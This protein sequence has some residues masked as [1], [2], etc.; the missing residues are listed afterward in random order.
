MAYC[1]DFEKTYVD[2]DWSRLCDHFTD[3]GVYDV[4]AEGFGCHLEGPDAIFTG[5][6]KS[7]DGFDR[8]FAERIIQLH[9]EPAVNGDEIS[10]SWQVT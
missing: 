4:K 2:E 6:K 7:L 3:D 1:A 8:K 9:G 10:V 5:M